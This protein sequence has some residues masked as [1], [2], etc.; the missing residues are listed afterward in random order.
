MALT[1]RMCLRAS[2]LRLHHRPPRK[3]QVTAAAL[4]YY[5][6]NKAQLAAGNGG[7]YHSQSQCTELINLMSGLVVPLSS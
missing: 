4:H 7:L 3:S 1:D 5:A 6:W 2:S